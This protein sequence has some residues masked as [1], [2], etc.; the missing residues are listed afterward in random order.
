MINFKQGFN[1]INVN[2]FD[3]YCCRLSVIMLYCFIIGSFLDHHSWILWICELGI[4][5]E[6]LTPC[7]T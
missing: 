3:K 1:L 2:C 6:L 5:A 4:G 7:T